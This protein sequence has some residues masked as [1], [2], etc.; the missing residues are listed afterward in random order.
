MLYICFF[1]E[2]G[3]AMAKQLLIPLPSTSYPA[4]PDGSAGCGFG[5]ELGPLAGGPSDRIDGPERFH[6]RAPAV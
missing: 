2:G 3:E 4:A 1:V 5:S 6:K